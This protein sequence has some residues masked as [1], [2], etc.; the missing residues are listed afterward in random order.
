MV[1]WIENELRYGYYSTGQSWENGGR[2]YIQQSTDVQ[3]VSGNPLDAIDFN[4]DI[5]AQ[6]AI[7]NIHSQ[8]VEL[9]LI[10]L[11]DSESTTTRSQLEF[12][13]SE[14]ASI[15]QPVVELTYNWTPNNFT[16]PI[17][18]E[19]PVGGQGVWNIS[20]H[21]FSGNQTRV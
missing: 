6:K 12:Y 18:L 8:H 10:G 1:E 4:F 3:F 14:S 17:E 2:D 16:E 21:N 11:G 13:S 7:Q 9:A 15:N 19:E 5:S 20:G